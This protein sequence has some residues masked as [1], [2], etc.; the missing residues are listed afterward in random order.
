MA[1]ES[2]KEPANCDADAAEASKSPYAIT[3]HDEHFLYVL[4]QYFLPC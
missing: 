2:K 4:L 3:Y 1:S